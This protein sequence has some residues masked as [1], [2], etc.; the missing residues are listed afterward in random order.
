[1]PAAIN[2]TKEKR[3]KEI[4]GATP[5]DYQS[6]SLAA[7]MREQDVFLSMRAGIAKVFVIR[8]SCQFEVICGFSHSYFNKRKK[9]KN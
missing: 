6:S 3:L 2:V 5:T 7:M 1:M 9:P 8:V 4:F